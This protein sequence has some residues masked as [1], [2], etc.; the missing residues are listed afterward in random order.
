MKKIKLKKYA[1]T[2]MPSKKGFA[3]NLLK[4]GETINKRYLKNTQYINAR[5]PAAALKK[6]SARSYRQETGKSLY[7]KKQ[8]KGRKK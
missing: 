7:P 8:S 3:V 6:L 1:I 5:S 2:Y 4:K